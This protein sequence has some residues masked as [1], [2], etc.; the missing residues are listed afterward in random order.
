M[1]DA[2]NRLE[3]YVRG[4]GADEL[5]QFAAFIAARARFHLDK[6]QTPVI[7]SDDIGLACSAR[8]VAL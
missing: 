1:T 8:P 4:M 6:H 2:K 7:E 3:E 5:A